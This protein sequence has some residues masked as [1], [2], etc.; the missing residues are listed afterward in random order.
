[1]PTTMPAMV[2]AG[3]PRPLEGAI[4]TVADDVATITGAPVTVDDDDCGF[5]IPDDA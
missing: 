4:V 2:S 5:V 1:M 3:V